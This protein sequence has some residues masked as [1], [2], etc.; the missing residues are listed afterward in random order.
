MPEKT[1][2]SFRE[3]S[4]ELSDAERNGQLI[5]IHCHLC[6][7]THNYRPADLIAVLGNQRTYQIAAFFRCQKCRKK[8]YMS[9]KLRSYDGSAIGKL[10]I[11]KLVEVYRV[12]KSRWK[13]GVL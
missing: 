12:K 1:T 2:F 4:Y 10:P 9:S 5:V 7:L 13:D 3:K 6:K 11:R 8:D